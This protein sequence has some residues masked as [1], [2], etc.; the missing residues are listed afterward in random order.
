VDVRV[1]GQGAAA[2]IA[3]AVRAL[4]RR[5]RA[6]GVDVILVTRGGGSM[7]DLWAFNERAVADAIVA[8]PIPVVAAIGHE[9]DTTVAELCAD[10]RGATPTQAAM[11]IA[12]DAEA[13]RRQ[14]AS[15]GARL[16]THVGRQIDLDA[17]RL[18]GAARH[19]LFSD[20][21]RVVDEAEGSLELARRDLA[22]AARERVRLAAERLDRAHRRLEGHRP[23]AVYARID[24]RLRGTE[25]RLRA[26]MGDA[27]CRHNPKAMGRRLA[28]AVSAG[29][30][31][32]GLTL[33]GAARALDLVGPQS[34][35]RR[36]YSITTRADG[37]PVRSSADV[38]AGETV[39]TRV[40]DGAFASVVTGDG[41]AG[42]AAPLPP[43]RQARAGRKP[44]AAE[45]PAQAK[46]F[47]G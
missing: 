36:G 32:R 42:G 2:E 37:T 28:F 22:H 35:L 17:Q 27:L 16:R 39:R 10:V 26:A 38:I 19:P 18:R 30:Q 1:Q 44:R 34:V 11:R 15:L 45:D 21:A 40:A 41:P 6:L 29:L 3:A 43:S 4:G 47:G 12:P 46:L 24:A 7:E 13:L 5:H 20:P 14:L 31:R 8:S 33:E 9:T 23:D 25:A